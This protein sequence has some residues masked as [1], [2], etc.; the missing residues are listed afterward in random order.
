MGTTI[1]VD[2]GYLA[3]LRIGCRTHRAVVIGR[4]T[5][6]RRDGSHTD[7]VGYGGQ[8]PHARWPGDAPMAV[9]FVL[10]YEEGS[11]YS[12]ANGN[13]FKQDDLTEAGPPRSIKTRDLG[14][15]SLFEYG[16]RAG[17]GA[18]RRAFTERSVPLTLYGC[19]MALE[20]NPP[21]AAAIARTDWDIAGHGWRWMETLS[22][23]RRGKSG[24]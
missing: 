20:A 8:P 14:A 23:W 6:G 16:A 7:V 9:N 17:S 11:E 5:K 19:A 13:S 18:W 24:R 1:V 3:E 15:E 4:H 10:N 21:A 22:I 12:V 2:G